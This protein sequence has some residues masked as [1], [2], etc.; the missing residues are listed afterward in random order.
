MPLR[1]P[2]LNM[3]NFQAVSA[4]DC[5]TVWP[6]SLR[7]RCLGAG[8]VSSSSSVSRG[9]LG[10]AG[11]FGPSA[12]VR[13]MLLTIWAA[14]LLARR[15]RSRKALLSALETIASGSG[16]S[17]KYKRPDRSGRDV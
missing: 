2:P 5:M 12:K 15:A 4:L 1:Y 3:L 14:A 17:L 9:S 10:G 7:R 6:S 8:C 11:V 13:L 16:E